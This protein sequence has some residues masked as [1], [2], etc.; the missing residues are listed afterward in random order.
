MKFRNRRR[1]GQSG[2]SS[3]VVDVGDRYFTS[4]AQGGK[5]FLTQAAFRTNEINSDR[6]DLFIR[7][8]QAKVG[9]R[10]DIFEPTS[11]HWRGETMLQY[12]TFVLD[13]RGR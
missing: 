2:F 8:D 5:A 7:L 11:N 12:R 13:L 4:D 3:E 1:V 6:L 9:I 10:L